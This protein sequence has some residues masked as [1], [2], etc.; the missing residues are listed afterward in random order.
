MDLEKRVRD[1][2]SAAA[3]SLVVPEPA[4]DP[5]GKRPRF[6]NSRVMVALAG[7]AAVVVVVAIPMFLLDFGGSESAGPVTTA[8][9]TTTIATTTTSL[10]PGPTIGSYGLVLLDTSD[11][12]TRFVMAAEKIDAEDPP[13]ATVKLLALPDGGDEP[14]DEVVVGDPGGF[15]WNSVTE[16]TG[17]CTTDFSSAPEAA[18]ITFQVR[19]SA[20]LGC[21]APF[22]Y[23]VRDGVLS[24]VP[25][26]AEA[27]ANLFMSVWS[28]GAEQTTMATLASADAIQQAS[29]LGPP[30]QPVLT[31]CE[32]AAGSVY[33][34]WQDARQD[35]VVRVDNV[36]QPPVVAEVRS[37]G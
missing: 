4:G 7:A 13:T 3:E 6:R 2:L 14:F 15:F 33:C 26:S 34:T 35:I 28:G 1:N 19:L 37:G 10:S 20:S 24:E 16:P 30:S 18:R 29:E 12:G 21:T 23:E 31:G 11:G 22:A 17:I 32:G 8:G 27:V 36:D 25:P 9:S 5:V